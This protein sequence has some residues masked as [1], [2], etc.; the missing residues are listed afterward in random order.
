MYQQLKYVS[1]NIEYNYKIQ[2]SKLPK[3]AFEL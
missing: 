2:A 1:V 3:L